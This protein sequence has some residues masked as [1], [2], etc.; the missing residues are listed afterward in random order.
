MDHARRMPDKIA[1]T[2]EYVPAA[3][4]IGYFGKLRLCLLRR[5]AF[6][7]VHDN[8][9]VHEYRELT[10]RE[11]DELKAQTMRCESPYRWY[12][13]IRALEWGILKR[14]L[15]ERCVR[16]L[17]PVPLTV[18]ALEWL[19]LL[20]INPRTHRLFVLPSIQDVHCEHDDARNAGESVRASWILARGC[21]TVIACWLCSVIQTIK[22]KFPAL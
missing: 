11:V 3:C 4:R 17:M 5:R 13:S 8:T 15:S 12:L 2:S 1:V 18:R 7:L 19:S 9:D 10:S 20:G 6:I 21:A 22:R 14:P 16:V